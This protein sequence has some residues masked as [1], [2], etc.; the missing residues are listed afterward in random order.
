MQVGSVPRQPA[1]VECRAFTS[2]KPRRACIT[3]V[4]ARPSTSIR[5]IARMEFGSRCVDR[6]P[7]HPEVAGQ[8][9]HGFATGHPE[10]GQ[11]TA[12]E[13][14]ERKHQA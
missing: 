5:V 1:G 3:F 2:G 7:H 14:I 13:L 8:A 11:E 12:V 10:G 6:G 4:I 9:G